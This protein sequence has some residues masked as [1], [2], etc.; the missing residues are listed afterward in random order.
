MTRR[1]HPVTTPQRGQMTNAWG[2]RFAHRPFGQDLLA[3]TDNDGSYAPT[4]R[5]EIS[6]DYHGMN[7]LLAIL[8]RIRTPIACTE[9]L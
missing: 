2:S 1:T 4:R 5:G 8:I 7:F 6:N 3:R 9:E